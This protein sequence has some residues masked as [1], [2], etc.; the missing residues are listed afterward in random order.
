MMGFD[1]INWIQA[2]S[3]SQFIQDII[4]MIIERKS[5][6]MLI[7]LDHSLLID[8]RIEITAR[9]K[10]HEINKFNTI[11][12]MGLKSFDDLLDNL[13]KLYFESSIKSIAVC[14][15]F[16]YDESP[17]N[18]LQKANALFWHIHNICD[19]TKLHAYIRLPPHDL[20]DSDPF[21]DRNLDFPENSQ[22]KVISSRYAYLVSSE[23]SSS[24]DPSSSSPPK[25]P[26]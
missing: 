15:W 1:K 11:S 24:L 23:A 2:T 21:W 18:Q 7:Y 16:C 5:V 4:N 10:V 22:L 6:P 19:F 26:F 20:S 9:M 12:L 8:L 3:T 17:E 13:K 25:A 14:N